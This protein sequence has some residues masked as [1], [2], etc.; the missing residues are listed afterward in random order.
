MQRH[1]QEAD[2]AAGLDDDG[3]GDGVLAVTAVG[4]GPGGQGQGQQRQ[5]LAQADEAQIQAGLGD[6]M[7]AAGDLIDLPQQGRG[8]DLDAQHRRHPPEPQ[9]AEIADG[10]GTG[11]AAGR[12]RRLDRFGRLDGFGHVRRS[13]FGYGV[14]SRWK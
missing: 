13:T 6:G 10:P 5:E 1:E 14:P 3:Q 12:R 4:Q 2:G 8:L 7:V 9:Q 11:R